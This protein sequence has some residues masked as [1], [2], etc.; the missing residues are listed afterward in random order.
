MLH[1]PPISALSPPPPEALDPLHGQ[2]VKF[3][4][5]TV[6]GAT[7]ADHSAQQQQEQ[8]QEQ[9]QHHYHQSV[10]PNRPTPQQQEHSIF[11]AKNC[12]PVDD[13]EDSA[14]PSSSHRTAT[15]ADIADLDIVLARLAE[16]HFRDESVHELDTLATFIALVKNSANGRRPFIFHLMS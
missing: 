1:P 4:S 15:L 5:P 10:N 11:S 14:G 2:L 16:R 7:P 6:T 13:D 12:R 8:Q 3:P 9:Q